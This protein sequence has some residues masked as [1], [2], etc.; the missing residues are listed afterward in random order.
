MRNLKPTPYIVFISVLKSL[1]KKLFPKVAKA[2]CQKLQKFYFKLTIK[3]GILFTQFKN[4][5]PF[6]AKTP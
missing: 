2:E 1:Q 3:W 6:G 4:N 5:I